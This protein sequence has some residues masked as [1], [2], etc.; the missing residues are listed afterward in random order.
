MQCF[1]NFAQ[2]FVGDVFLRQKNVPYLIFLPYKTLRDPASSMLAWFTGGLAYP[3]TLTFCLK[4]YPITLTFCLKAYPI[5]LTSVYFR[6]K[7]NTSN[8]NY[9]SIRWFGLI[10]FKS[11]EPE[12]TG[13][14][15]VQ[16]NIS[17]LIVFLFRRLS[18]R[19]VFCLSSAMAFLNV[20]RILKIG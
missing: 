9:V 11:F 4:A 2:S 10:L 20:C 3:I 7:S 5:T 13:F 15:R 12:R 18:S 6:T 16:N 1:S 19:V 14:E 8:C 17:P